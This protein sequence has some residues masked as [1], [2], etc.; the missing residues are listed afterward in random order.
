MHRKGQQTIHIDGGD[1]N[2]ILGGNGAEGDL[3]LA[4]ERGQQTVHI[5]GGEGNVTL[6]GNGH[7]GDI[8]MTTSS[9]V[10]RIEL[11]AHD[12]NIRAN[13]AQGETTVE[14]IGGSGE[15]KVKGDNVKGAD[16]VFAADY[17]LVPLAQVEDFRKS[18][19]TRCCSGCNHA[20]GRSRHEPI[21]YAAFG[22]G[23][24]ADPA[25]D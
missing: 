5:D 12:G 14:I 13:N 2:I 15:I 19:S 25:R 1:G 9:G 17:D 7:D 4:D 20:H 23:R 10:C 22:K 11:E 21:G 6:G 8:I 18:P 24:G 16:H 3:T